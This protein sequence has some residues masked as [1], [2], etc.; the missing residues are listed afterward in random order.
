MER[1]LKKRHNGP[2]LC[3]LCRGELGDVL[4]AMRCGHW[5]L[6][7]FARPGRRQPLTRS[8][9]VFVARG[10]RE[11]SNRTS[12]APDGPGRTQRAAL[13]GHGTMGAN[14]GGKPV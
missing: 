13:A 5:P 2:G 12:L 4:V 1:A 8:R 11:Y 7:L 3:P 9:P 10:R 6:A 14:K